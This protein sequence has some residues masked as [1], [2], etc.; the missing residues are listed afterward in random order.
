MNVGLYSGAAGMRVGE[1]YQQ[2]ISENLSLQSVPGYKQTLPVFSTDP[3]ATSSA[4]QSTSS[5]NPAAVVMNRVVDFSQGPVEPSSSPYHVAIQGQ[6]FFQVREA[7]GSTTYTRNGSFDLSTTGE[8]K[9]S[10][11]A[12]V[13]GQGGSPIKIDTTQPG[14]VTI[15]SDGTISVGGVQNTGLGLAHF[16]NPSASLQPGAFGRFVATNSSDAKNGLAPN[17]HIFQNSLEQSNGNPVSQMADMIQAVR[18]YEANS[19]SMKAVDDTQ[20]QLIT[21]LGARPQG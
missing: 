1:D 9:T 3:Q 12:T 14:P 18:I 19:K 16:D 7:D 21:N 20:N 15:G 2:L 17:D 4:M 8:L 13:L 6:A 10:D 5:G 11:G